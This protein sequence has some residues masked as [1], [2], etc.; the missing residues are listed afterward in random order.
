MCDHTSYFNIKEVV[1]KHWMLCFSLIIQVQTHGF[2]T[3]RTTFSNILKHHK[4]Y[5]HIRGNV[6]CSTLYFFSLSTQN[7]TEA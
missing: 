6:C 1:K 7:T 4:S 2:R 5:F 3:V